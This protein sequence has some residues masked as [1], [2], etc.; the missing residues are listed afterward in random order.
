[1][2]IKTPF[3]TFNK[4]VLLSNYNNYKKLFMDNTEICYAMK[5]NSEKIVLE[6]LNKAGASFEVASKYELALLKNIKVNPDKVI[7]GTSVKPELDIK[8]FKKYRVDRFA[9]DSSADLLKIS[10]QA[11]GAQVYVR[12]L[13][14]DK[15]NSVFKMSEKFGVPIK[16]GINLLKK[17]KE[18]GLVPY[19]ISFNV[20]SQARNVNAWGRG[21]ADL[22]KMMME[23]LQEG[24]KIQVVNIG[25]GFPF[26]YDDK[27]KFPEI[28]KIS[29]YVKKESK[30]LPYNV[31]FIV[32]PGRGLVADVFTL[33]TSVIGINKRA[34]GKWLYLDAGTYNALLESTMSQGSTKY[35]ITVLSTRNFSKKTK[36][37]ILSGP[38]GDN[39]DVINMKVLLPEDITIGDKL[40][41]HDVGAYTFTLM[42]PFNG[43]PKP[44]II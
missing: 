13:V 40:L 11:P 30:K 36:N 21:V 16:E 14:D 39:I 10:R 9:F 3:F 18:L 29:D 17:A 44:K 1:M 7:Y 24:I 27:T 33:T 22:S 38:T 41:I 6:A 32:E 20:G 19:G 5:A 8:D 42:T 26:S 31:K 35:K 23:L 34:S 28:R 2:N 15:S 4:K 12:V 25:G 43:F 37:F